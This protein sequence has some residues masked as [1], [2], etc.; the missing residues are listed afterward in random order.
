MSGH[1]TCGNAMVWAT[2]VS[3]QVRKEDGKAE[4]W[5]RAKCTWEQ[6]SRTAIILDYGDPREW[7]EVSHVG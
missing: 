5:L 6:R 3:Q 7:E 4:Q 2:K 1:S